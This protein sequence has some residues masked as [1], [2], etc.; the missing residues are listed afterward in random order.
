MSV[1]FSL[2]S[3]DPYLPGRDFDLGDVVG[4]NAWGAIWAA[5]ISELTWTSDPGVQVGWT[6]KLGN[7]AALADPD[8]LLARNAETVRGVISRISTFVG[9]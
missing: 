4:I 5:Y 3:V 7:L 1:E 8:A 9:S 6:I 2:E